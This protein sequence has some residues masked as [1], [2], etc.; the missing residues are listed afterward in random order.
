MQPILYL[1]NYLHYFLTHFVATTWYKS[2]CSWPHTFFSFTDL[3]LWSMRR[4]KNCSIKDLCVKKGEQLTHSA[5][6]KNY[7]RTSVYYQKRGK[8]P[9][10][11]RR[12]PS[13]LCFTVAC[14]CAPH[15][16]AKGGPNW[17][18]SFSYD[19]FLCHTPQICKLL[20]STFWFHSFILNI[21][22]H[23]LSLIPS[24]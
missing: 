5:A 3:I 23:D 13:Q 20:T 11:G 22:P 14:Q 1:D 19:I 4:T 16:L 18:E 12:G 17:L 21:I 24:F 9:R 10:G 6:F 7:I 15:L 2:V 8:L